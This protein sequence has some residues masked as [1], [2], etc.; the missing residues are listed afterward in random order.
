MSNRTNARSSIDEQLLS[1]TS[2]EFGWIVDYPAGS[3]IEAIFVSQ[4]T[5]S[6]SSHLSD[7][8][9]HLPGIMVLPG[10]STSW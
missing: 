2:K 4:D 9:V 10:E 3:W 6:N 1:T 5:S 7:T 8:T